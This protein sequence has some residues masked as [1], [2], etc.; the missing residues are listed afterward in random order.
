M[1]RVRTRPRSSWWLGWFLLGTAAGAGIVQMVH[2][3]AAPVPSELPP[4][5]LE[6]TVFLPLVDHEGRALP[7][8]EW[9][10]GVDVFVERFGGATLGARCEGCWRDAQG[11]PSREPVRP[12]VVSFEA[13]RLPEFRQSLL[14]VGR[15][16]KQ[17]VLYTRYEEP[18]IELLRVEPGEASP[19][20]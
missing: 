4:R 3:P 5:R 14:A 17:D 11:K 12:V 8:A 1:L 19:A 20:P 15:L 13:G 16:L 18:R 6:A 9:Q 7:E 2:R 10:S